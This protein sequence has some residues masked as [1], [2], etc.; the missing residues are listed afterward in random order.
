MRTGSS[1]RS[2]SGRGSVLVVMVVRA[3]TGPVGSASTARL[4]VVPATVR[5]GSQLLGVVGDHHP[6][7][8]GE[9]RVVVSEVRQ[10][11]AHAR[12]FH[13]WHRSG[14]GWS[15]GGS[16]SRTGSK[17]GTAGH[18]AAGSS[19]GGMSYG[20]SE[21][22]RNGVH[23]SRR[24]KVHDAGVGLFVAVDSDAA[25]PPSHSSPLSRTVL[26]ERWLRD[27]SRASSTARY[28]KAAATRRRVARSGRACLRGGH[29]RLRVRSGS[30]G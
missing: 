18:R 19:C 22:G 23:Q 4:A 6:H 12:A 26:F 24:R 2:S 17:C 3:L 10:R 11:G 28:A 14:Q 5:T 15:M 13:A 20:C 16:A 29:A 30:V 8:D 27:S 25:R 21:E 1:V 7:P 9:R